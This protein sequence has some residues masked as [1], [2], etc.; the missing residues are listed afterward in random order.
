M[1][2]SMKVL[3]SRNVHFL[4]A[5]YFFQEC[6]PVMCTL[7]ILFICFWEFKIPLFCVA[8]LDTMDEVHITA[9]LRWHY[10]ETLTK[11]KWFLGILFFQYSSFWSS[12]VVQFL[13]TDNYNCNRQLCRRYR[14]YSLYVMSCIYSAL[15]LII[16]KVDLQFKLS[17]VDIC[18]VYNAV[19]YILWRMKS[20]W[21][22]VV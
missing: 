11:N 1:E 20:S 2:K 17:E 16:L 9:L 19:C 6:L 22:A 18:G 12:E 3:S 14:N 10:I 15:K 4:Y 13:D 21:C 8:V 5:S 7:R